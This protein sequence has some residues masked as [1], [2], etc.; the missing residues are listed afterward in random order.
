MEI[1]T[2][3]QASIMTV[4]IVQVLKNFMPEKTPTWVYSVLMIVLAFGFVAITMFAP[5]WIATGI[6]TVCVAQLGYEGI[7][8]TIKKMAGK[9][10]D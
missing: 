10:G 8:Q 7:I 2:I 1:E 9:S 4:G 3:T 6:I 5:K